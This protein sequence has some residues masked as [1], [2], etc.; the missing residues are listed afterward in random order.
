M[1]LARSRAITLPVAL[2][3]VLV[4]CGG[5]GDAQAFCNVADDESG[6]PFDATDPEAVRGSLQELRDTAPD[7]IRDDVLA[8]VDPLEE[9]FDELES[10]EGSD[11]PEAAMEGLA[12]ME[13]EFDQ[14]AADRVETWID[15]NC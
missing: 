9:M 13:Q 3:F 10:L 2:A 15:E 1:R 11:D 6:D 4:A 8:V 14:E 5:G 7:E 12:A